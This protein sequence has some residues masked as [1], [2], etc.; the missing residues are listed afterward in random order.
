MCHWIEMTHRQGAYV[1]VLNWKPCYT[2]FVIDSLS[3][4]RMGLVLHGASCSNGHRHSHHV[5]LE[6]RNGHNKQHNI[7]VRAAVIH[8]LG[9]FIQSVGVL[10]SALIIKFY[11]RSLVSMYLGGTVTSQLVVVHIAE[12]EHCICF[13][14][15]GTIPHTFRLKKCLYS[16]HRV[17]WVA[18]FS[19]RWIF[20]WFYVTLKNCVHCYTVLFLFPA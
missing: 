10:V 16:I 8:V 19:S 3:C 17:N 18:W 6:Q 15:L 2:R 14:V 13:Y 4:C 11:V 5:Q 12:S 9:D 1:P 20:W 7:N